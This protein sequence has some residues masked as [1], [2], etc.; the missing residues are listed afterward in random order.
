[1]STLSER[2]QSLHT[3]MIIRILGRFTSLLPF[4]NLHTTRLTALWVSYTIKL[5]KCGVCSQQ[6]Y[7]VYKID[8]ENGSSLLI[9]CTM[10]CTIAHMTVLPLDLTKL[11]HKESTDFCHHSGSELVHCS[12]VSTNNCTALTKQS[13]C[14]PSTV[15]GSCIM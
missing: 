4:D 13:L 14:A 1:M 9:H 5:E 6:V 3:N 15:A 2:L 8:M 12:H 7:T 11:I 10:S